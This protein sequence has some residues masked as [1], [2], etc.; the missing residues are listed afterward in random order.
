MQTAHLRYGWLVNWLNCDASTNG[1]LTTSQVLLL[2]NSFWYWE[3]ICLPATLP[4][5]LAISLRSNQHGCLLFHTVSLHISGNG[6]MCSLT[7][8]VPG[9]TSS[10]TS[11]VLKA[12]W[13]PDHHS[14]DCLH[15]TSISFSV[16]DPPKWNTTP[17]KP[18][19]HRS[20][21]LSLQ[22]LMWCD[23]MVFRRICLPLPQV[24]YSTFK[25][26]SLG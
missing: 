21:L 15:L 5:G 17:S 11:V 9:G 22:E 3:E 14:P 4:I 13:L 1:K 7:L 2:A 23:F 8:F 18:A 20:A 19:L 16:C 6:G 25:D 26:F 12:S 24:W 10:V